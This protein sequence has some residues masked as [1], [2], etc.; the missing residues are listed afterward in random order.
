MME[1]LLTQIT[2][3]KKMIQ[4]R[5]TVEKIKKKKS[6]IEDDNQ[7]DSGVTIQDTL[8]YNYCHFII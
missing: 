2:V 4:K 3:E 5:S 8:R 7:E 6:S 1:F